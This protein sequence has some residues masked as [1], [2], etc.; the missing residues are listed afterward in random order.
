MQPMKPTLF[1]NSWYYFDNMV[2]PRALVHSQDVPHISNCLITDKMKNLALEQSYK[3]PHTFRTHFSLA[4]AR[5][6][7]R[8]N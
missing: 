6:L 8:E 3:R 5:G 4:T 2:V 1:I 7:I